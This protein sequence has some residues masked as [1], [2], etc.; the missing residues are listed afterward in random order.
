MAYPIRK[1]WYV[2]VDITH[3]DVDVSNGRSSM[4]N[5]FDCTI[6]NNLNSKLQQQSLNVY[7]FHKFILTHTK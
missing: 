4:I 3:G 7:T 1:S 6:I 2:I 5:R